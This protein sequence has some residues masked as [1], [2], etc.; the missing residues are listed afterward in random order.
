M[1]LAIVI[2]NY[3]S[4][5]LIESNIAGLAAVPTF[6]VD[7]FSSQ[8]N[9]DAA[10]RLATMRGWSFIAAE[11]NLGFGGGVNIGVRAAAAAGHDAVLLVNPDL[12][13]DA[14]AVAAIGQ[15]LARDPMAIVSPMVLA[16][17]GGTYFGGYAV[18]LSSGRMTRVEDV[19]RPPAATLAWISGACMAFTVQLFDQVGGFD[20]SYFLYWEDVEFSVRASTSPNITLDVLKGVSV[21]HDENGTQEPTAGRA[22]SNLYYRY[23]CRNRLLFAAQHLDTVTLLRWMLYTPRQSYLILLQGGR[24]QLLHSRQP[25]WAAARGTC[26]GL[27]ICVREMVSRALDALRGRRKRRPGARS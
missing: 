27:A 17:D 8:K 24:R 21:V 1:G 19:Q 20:E 23:C 5:E 9:R 10:R 6:I 16:P 12:R 11:D 13:L 18:R 22:K 3:G 2:V 4:H 15:R 14:P 7:N 26:E 25:L